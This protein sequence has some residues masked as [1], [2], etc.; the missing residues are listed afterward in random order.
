[1]EQLL[2][3]SIKIKCCGPSPQIKF[4]EIYRSNSD[5]Y[6]DVKL[7]LGH[8]LVVGSIDGAEHV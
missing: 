6:L 1:M 4:G 8:N 3:D 2:E 5:P 7:E